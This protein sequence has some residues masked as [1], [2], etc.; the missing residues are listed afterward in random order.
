VA[1]LMD[2]VRSIL[3]LGEHAEEHAD[4]RRELTEQQ[5]RIRRLDAYV[6]ARMGKDRRRR[7]TP[8]HPQRRA[9]DG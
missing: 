6:E 9:S 1:S 5:S 2:H 8:N 3:G 7:L 4:V